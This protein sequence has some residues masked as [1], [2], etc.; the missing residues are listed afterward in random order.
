MSMTETVGFRLTVSVYFCVSDFC[1]SA[2]LT[3]YR[4]V[5]RGE[6]SAVIRARV[7]PFCTFLFVKLFYMSKNWRWTE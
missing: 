6:S 5:S 4:K 2:V 7:H 1:N 3:C